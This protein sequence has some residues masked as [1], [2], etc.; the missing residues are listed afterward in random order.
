MK[1]IFGVVLVT[2]IVGCGPSKKIQ[3]RDM[4]ALIL[5]AK[6]I[7]AY[8]LDKNGVYPASLDDPK[9]LEVVGQP[10]RLEFKNWKTGEVARPWYLKGQ[11]AMSPAGE[12]LMA[13]PWV[14]GKKRVVVFCNSSARVLPESRFQEELAKIL[15]AGGRELV[16]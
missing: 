2:M 10:K 9:F 12:I 16:K 4:R 13:S 1:V 7:R 3:S 5:L 6:A 15:E 14:Y 11:T 8:S